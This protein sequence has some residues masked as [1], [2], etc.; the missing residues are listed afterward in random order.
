MAME[1]YRN[2]MGL[3]YTCVNS[4]IKRY[5]SERFFFWTK[6]NINYIKKGHSTLYVKAEHPRNPAYIYIYI[7]I[8]TMDPTATRA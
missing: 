1:E 6:D 8:V 2:L 4:I 7:T 3:Y 5:Y